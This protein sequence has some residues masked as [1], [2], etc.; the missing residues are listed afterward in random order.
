M[1]IDIP[2]WPTLCSYPQSF[3]DHLME[4][5]ETSS[6]NCIHCNI[7]K[8]LLEVEAIQKVRTNQE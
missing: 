2:F 8:T 4:E 5:N 7:F 6:S 1:T 3:V